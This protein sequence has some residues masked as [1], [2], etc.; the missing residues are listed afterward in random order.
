MKLMLTT[1]PWNQR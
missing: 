1:K